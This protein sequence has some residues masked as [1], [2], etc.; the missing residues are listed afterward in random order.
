MSA[1]GDYIHLHASRYIKYGNS[2]LTEGW[3]QINSGAY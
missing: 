2:E 1:I 3:Q